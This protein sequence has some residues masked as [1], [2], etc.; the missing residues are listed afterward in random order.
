MQRNA[1]KTQ[2][3]TLMGA[4][5][6]MAALLVATLVFTSSFPVLAQPQRALAVTEET[7]AEPDELQQRVE[8]SAADYD[9]AV[10]RVEELEQQIADN[11]EQIAAIEE[12]LPEQQERAAD[13]MR[14][15]YK[16]QR[17]AP[18]ILEMVLGSGSLSDF[19]S[20]WDYFT[21]VQA[22]NYN[23]LE[24]LDQ[25]RQELEATEQELAAA[26]DEAVAQ[27]S[28]A[29][30][31][32]ADA[33]AAREEAQRRAE[34]EAARQAEEAARAAEAAAAQEQ[35]AQQ[36]QSSGQTQ[37][38]QPEAQAPAQEPTVE[39]PSSDG[40]DWSSDKA[41]FV[42]QWAGRI[43]AYLAGSPLAGQ[44]T[45][46]ASAAWDYGVDPRWSPAISNTESSKGLYCFLPHNAWGW[47]SYS[48]GSWEEAINAHVRGLARGYGYTISVEAAKKYCPPNWEHW[49]NA[50]L[51]QMNM[52]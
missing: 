30:Q 50:T 6:A 35:Q 43:D 31:A 15:Q 7:E 25:M 20:S 28:A 5:I 47:G 18:G 16:F 52:I 38:Q 22:R 23:E 40:A 29:E 10:A 19:L 46:F 51:A 21:H 33:Q 9:A 45:T 26:R 49:Y 13:A 24:R 4:R 42:S 8:Q 37:T 41:T 12:E 36:N 3:S 27:Q 48:W 14:D 32:L 39:T 11:Q 2:E 17:E 44:G 34:E 1:V